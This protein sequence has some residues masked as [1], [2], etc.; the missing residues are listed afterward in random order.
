[1]INWATNVIKDIQHLLM[2]PVVLSSHAI[3]N[4]PVLI[5]TQNSP[6]PYLFFRLQD[7]FTADQ[8]EKVR[9]DGEKKN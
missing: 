3:C 1:M 9:A 2:G 5:A 8:C 7:H 4:V 6:F